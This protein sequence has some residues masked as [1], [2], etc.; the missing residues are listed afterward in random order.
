MPRRHKSHR[1]TLS[2][3]SSRNK[4]KSVTHAT[5]E[6]RPSSSKKRKEDDYCCEPPDIDYYPE[7]ICV[8][9]PDCCDDADSDPCIPLCCRPCPYWER[10]IVKFNP[11]AKW[12]PQIEEKGESGHPNLKKDG[13]GNKKGSSSKSKPDKNSQKN[14]KKNNKKDD[15]FVAIEIS[16]KTSSNSNVSNVGRYICNFQDCVPDPCRQFY[17]QLAN[18]PYNTNYYQQAR[19]F[20]TPN[21]PCSSQSPENNDSDDNED[22]NKRS[23]IP[24]EWL[25]ELPLCDERKC[26]NLRRKTC[27]SKKKKSNGGQTRYNPYYGEDG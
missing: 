16:H 3:S 5:D 15:K 18:Q 7:C 20:Q 2:S 6:D 10:E 14:D 11:G 24:D 17:P 26:P 4:R 19:L 8:S 1:S 27:K 23:K 21:I 12:N 22:T 9:P 13:D 25:Q